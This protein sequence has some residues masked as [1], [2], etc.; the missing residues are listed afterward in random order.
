MLGHP[1]KGYEIQAQEKVSAQ[2]HMGYIFKKEKTYIKYQSLSTILELPLLSLPSFFLQEHPHMS[3]ALRKQFY[4][5]S[6][7]FVFH[8]LSF[9]KD[10]HC[11]ELINPPPILLTLSIEL[12]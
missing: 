3:L 1:I 10:D 5:T 4:S 7:S 11:S 12:Y 2:V 6:D 9:T 8:R